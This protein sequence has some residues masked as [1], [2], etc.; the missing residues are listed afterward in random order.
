MSDKATISVHFDSYALDPVGTGGWP[1]GWV[2][3]RISIGW[4]HTDT[5]H[6]P[7]CELRTSFHVQ[8]WTAAAANGDVVDLFRRYEFT[9]EDT[10]RIQRWLSDF[11]RQ[12]L[13]L[14]PNG[15]AKSEISVPNVP[16]AHAGFHPTITVEDLF[17]RM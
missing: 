3:V 2:T 6:L 11:G 4:R 17:R 1:R 8:P 14:P 12:C 13:T 7:R 16:F 10:A 15:S 9:D 5:H